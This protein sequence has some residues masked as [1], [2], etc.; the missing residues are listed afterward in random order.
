MRIKEKKRGEMESNIYDGKE[1]KV[2]QRGSEK[3][4]SEKAYQGTQGRFTTYA[5]S[6][7]TVKTS[8]PKIQGRQRNIPDSR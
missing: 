4:M 5:R 3:R 2:E 1:T 6:T 7:L 8:K